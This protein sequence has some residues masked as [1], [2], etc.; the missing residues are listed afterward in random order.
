MNVGK[1]KFLYTAHGMSTSLTVFGKQFCFFSKYS[2]FSFKMTHL[3]NFLVSISIS[4]QEIKNYL[5]KKNLHFLFPAALSMIT[6]ILNQPM[7]L[8][9]DDW[10]E[11]LVYKYNVILFNYDKKQN[12]AIFSSR[13]GW[14]SQ[15]GVRCKIISYVGY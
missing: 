15:P 12:H 10:I 1:R 9:T 11:K 5:F 2:V 13:N 14:L 8:R 4:I 3:F 6:K 7:F